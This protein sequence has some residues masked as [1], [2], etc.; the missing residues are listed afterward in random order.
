MIRFLVVGFTI[1]ETV[2][3]LLMFV[4][5]YFLPLS[6][7]SFIELVHLCLWPSSLFLMV[8]GGG[9]SPGDDQI[10]AL[11]IFVNGILYAVVSL[12]IWALFFRKTASI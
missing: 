11:S 6:I 5:R 2:P 12:A 7:G 1:G 10:R 4:Y 9:D 3:L 8:T